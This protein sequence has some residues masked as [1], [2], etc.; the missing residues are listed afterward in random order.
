MT[1]RLQDR[2]VAFGVIALVLLAGCG[3]NPNGVDAYGNPIDPYG[4]GYS[5]PYGSSDPYGGST[6]GGGYS[7]P[8]GSNSGSGFGGGYG[9]TGPAYGNSTGGT[10]SMGL[11]ELKIG[12][13]DKSRKG[14]WF[15]RRLTVASQITNPSQVV[16]T[17]E[18][19]ISFMKGSKVVETQTEFVTD[20]APGQAHSFSATSKKAADDVQISVLSKPG[21]APSSGYGNGSTGFGS[22]YGSSN[23]GPSGG[24][25]GGSNPYGGGSGAG[26]GYGYG[27]Y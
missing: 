1:H 21:Q 20:L 23:G 8:Y 2:S 3:A 9:A 11:G 14:F 16:L 19:I 13:L 15:W 26:S 25:F 17:G 24:G 22:G 5:D 12:K 10:P 7:D 4:S 6:L 27:G 18:V